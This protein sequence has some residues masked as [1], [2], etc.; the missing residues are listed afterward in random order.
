M[1]KMAPLSLNSLLQSSQLASPAKVSALSKSLSR[2]AARRA[3]NA[4]K[5]RQL[6][7]EYEMEFDNNDSFGFNHIDMHL[8]EDPNESPRK[9]HRTSSG[10]SLDS[11]VEHDSLSTLI[12]ETDSF[13]HDKWAFGF[14]SLNSSNSNPFNLGHSNSFN[15]N[16]FT[17][18]N[19]DSQGL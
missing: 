10:Q 19:N 1:P 5:P 7:E 12:G 14:G 8:H 11:H 2:E 13:G 16:P 18:S 15:S 6:T 9:L 3:S 17:S 4:L